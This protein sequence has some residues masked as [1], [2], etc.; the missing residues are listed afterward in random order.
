MPRIFDNIELSFLPTLQ[1]SLRTAQKADF[2]V[3]YFNLRGWKEISS[4]IDNW[5][6]GEENCCRLMV[7]MQSA[8]QEELRKFFSL[9]HQQELDQSTIIRRK[10]E[11]ASSFK[12]QLTFG[13]PTNEDEKALRQ[14]SEQIKA[15]KVVVKLFLKHQLHAKLYLVHR[16]DHNNPTIGF[17]GS[18]NLTFA[19][20]SKQGELNVDVL[21]E[22]SCEK[23]QKWVDNRWDERW[24]LDISAELAEIIDT[25][26]ARTDLIPPYHIYLKI[27]YHLSQEA[28]AGLAEFHIPREF[29]N[30][31][32]DYQKAAVQIAA[33]HLKKRNG[34]LI[35]DVVG[36][37]KTLMATALA[38]LVEE[39]SGH[40]TLIICPKNLVK[41]WES[42]KDAYGLQAKVMSL[43]KV[44]K[45]LPEVPPRF[46]TVLIDESHNLRNRE[47]KRFRVIQ[48][49]IRA[50]DSRCILLSATPYNKSYLDLSAQLRLF[51][52]DDKDIGIRPE[53]FLREYGE[54]EFQSVYQ[55]SLRSLAAPC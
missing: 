17:V 53:K 7:G 23:L 16:N 37:G 34:V 31:L 51:V 41:M 36:L 24:C 47:G 38:K 42:Y 33:H 35:G 25:S 54:T 19:G 18:S 12:D 13:V 45:D 3:G 40:S 14:L 52:P 21:D 15:K 27:A 29:Q 11:I 50:S 43:S 8:P 2:C 46:R 48:D 30:V 20:L 32:F 55:S 39:D 28:R 5:K 26:W 44:I 6:G 4:Y 1:E 9:I 10:K 22:T 49:Y